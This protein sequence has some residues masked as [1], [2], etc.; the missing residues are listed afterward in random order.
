M[1]SLQLPSVAPS[2]E[3]TSGTSSR[4]SIPNSWLQSEIK[5]SSSSRGTLPPMSSGA[6]PGLPPGPSQTS[7]GKKPVGRPRKVQV[8]Q[9]C[10]GAAGAAVAGK[11]GPYTDWFLPELRPDLGAGACRAAATH[12]RRQP[13]FATAELPVLRVVQLSCPGPIRRRWRLWGTRHVTA[14]STRAPCG[15]GTSRVASQS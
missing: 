7:A 6:P 5:T 13:Q 14:S 9:A 4:P 11:R 12:V 8:L 2:K 10:D 3:V 1:S 15:G